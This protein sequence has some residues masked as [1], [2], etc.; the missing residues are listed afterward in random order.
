LPA[1]PPRC[2]RPTDAGP[3]D[4]VGDVHGCRDELDE[5]LRRLGYARDAT[6]LWTH[7]GARKVVFLGD[8][9]DRGPRIAD[10]L[11]TAMRMVEAGTA[12]CVTGNHELKLRQKLAGIDIPIGHGLDRSLAELDAAPSDFRQEV[13][14]FLDGLASHFVLDGGRLVVAH[15]GLREDLQGLESEAVLTFATVGETAGDD[16]TR[17]FPVPFAWVAG[18]AGSAAVVYG[19]T[20]VREPLW[21][22]RTINIDTG[23]VSGGRLTALRWP[24]RELV[25]V[26]ARRQYAAP[27][28]PL[29]EERLADQAMP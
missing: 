21:V 11:R 3:F 14:R 25:A 16:G 6:G 26:A 19:H 5:L 28:R 22:N 24:E 10:T 27:S 20:P 4:I 2:H 29:R 17:Q 15:A 8:L 1:D 9:V 23:C 12:L 18:Y 13:Q 7:P